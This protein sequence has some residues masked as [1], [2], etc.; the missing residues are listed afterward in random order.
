V[1]KIPTGSETLRQRAE[2]IDRAVGA[3]IRAKRREGGLTQGELAARL[4]LSYQQIQKYEAA[5]NRI[6]AGR[7]WALAQALEADIGDFFGDDGASRTVARAPER[8]GRA[9]SLR[10]LDRKV[11]AALIR[12][13]QALPKT[14]R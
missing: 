9:L 14:P 2:R 10:G 13:I 6:S 1:K 4:G 5:S 7:L 3:R 11:E 12:L 8:R